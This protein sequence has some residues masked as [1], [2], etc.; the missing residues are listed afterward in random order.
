MID[1][2][3]KIERFF[4]KI[5]SSIPKSTSI[6]II[7]GA[8]LLRRGLKAATKDID[9]IVESK[10]EFFN[11]QKAFTK[12]GFETVLPGREYSHM[13]LSQIFSKEDMRIDLFNREV[14]NKFSLTKTMKSRGE[15]ILILE[16]C[17]IHLCS[18]ED[19][20]LFKTMTEREG[21]LED[22]LSIATNQAL[23]WNLILEE[24]Q[25][26][27]TMTK[28][29]VWITWVAERL[30][31]LEERGLDIPI[32]KE[33]NLLRKYYFDELENRLEKTR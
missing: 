10:E 17:T 33:I 14:C 9:L 30:D 7:G 21:D 18:N 23:E 1:E 2:F 11:M 31:I 15:K 19:I 16:H 22:C 28:E 27:I 6:Y 5:D 24:L 26:Q 12:Q 4:R 29:S 3:N 32:M 13:N 25:Q 20:F 8:A